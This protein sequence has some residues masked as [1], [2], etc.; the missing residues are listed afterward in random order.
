MS[1]FIKK[2]SAKAGMPPGTLVYIGEEKKEEVRISV[3]D[4]N[5]EKLDEPDIHDIAECT[6]FCESPTITWINIDGLHD[7]G[8]IESL[9][10]NFG[11][12]ALHLED[13][14][15]TGGRPKF[16]DFGDYILIV[17]KMLYVTG[18]DHQIIAEH[19]SLVLGKNFVIS[20]QEKGEDVFDPIRKLIRNSKGKVRREGA[21]YL[22]YLLIDAVVDNYFK[23]FEKVGDIIEDT[24]E[25]VL[26]SPDTG[27]IHN[28]H[29]LKNDLLFLRRSILPLR[30]VVNEMMRGQTDLIRQTTEVNLRDVYDHI[31]QIMDTLEIERDLLSNLLD[32]Y[33]SFMSNR[34][35]EI[36]KFLTVFSTIFIPLTFLA[37]VYGMNFDFQPEIHWKWSYP[38]FWVVVISLASTMLIIF[39]KKRWL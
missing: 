35:N 10:K 20:F 28:I 8:L 21:D 22:M 31:I 27:S 16:E 32:T 9:G 26:N 25:A 29:H 7:T 13:I 18:E 3:M 12:N 1:R 15:N 17:L 4:Y 30:E 5:A 19:V 37:G 38:I 33:L 23:I 11:L 39:K 36:M 6:P 14:V 2:I 34:M 24:E